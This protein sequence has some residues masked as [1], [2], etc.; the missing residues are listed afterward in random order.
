MPFSSDRSRRSAGSGHRRLP[1]LPL[2][3]MSKKAAMAIFAPPEEFCG[4]HADLR[5]R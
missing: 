5:A 4:F 3:G 2:R 1:F